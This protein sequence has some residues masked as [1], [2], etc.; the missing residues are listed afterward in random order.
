VQRSRPSFGAT[1]E[2][3]RRGNLLD[4]TYQDLQLCSAGCLVFPSCCWLWNCR[5][6][7]LRVGAHVLCFRLQANLHT[8]TSGHGRNKHQHT[9][10]F[11]QRPVSGLFRYSVMCQTHQDSSPV[12]VVT[13]TGACTSQAQGVVWQHIHNAL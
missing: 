3:T 7:S 6:N 9:T 2:A 11:G 8:H 5:G 1:P 12:Y 10:T 4:P 13:H